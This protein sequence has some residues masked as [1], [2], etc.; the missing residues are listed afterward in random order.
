MRLLLLLQAVRKLSLVPFEQW[1]VRTENRVRLRDLIE[2]WVDLAGFKCLEDD[3]ILPFDFRFHSITIQIQ[4]LVLLLLLFILSRTY[5]FVEEFIIEVVESRRLKQVFLLRTLLLYLRNF[6]HS[7]VLLYGIILDFV[8]VGGLSIWSLIF[9]SSQLHELI[10]WLILL[11]L[12][13][14]QVLVWWI[15]WLP[16]FRFLLFL[17]RIFYVLVLIIFILML[18]DFFLYLIVGNGSVV[19][20]FTFRI[21]IW[22]VIVFDYIICFF[23]K[24]FAQLCHLRSD[25]R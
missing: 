19:L 14:C 8:H 23:L 6:T 17:N 1:L 22:T 3:R 13:L 21:S 10:V 25:V 9:L 11:D 15:L 16:V 7:A 5:M 2:S 24:A 4:C 18:F 12:A 20:A